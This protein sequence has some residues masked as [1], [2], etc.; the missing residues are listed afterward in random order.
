MNI[1]N[2]YKPF[3]SLTSLVTTVV[4]GSLITPPAEALILSGSAV[5]GGFN[6]QNPNAGVQNPLSTNVSILTKSDL[7]TLSNNQVG[8]GKIEG[9]DVFGLIEKQN[10]LLAD[11]L[12]VFGNYSFTDPNY[13][14]G[15]A[16]RNTLIK[17]MRVS[18]DLIWV[19]PVGEGFL[20]GNGQRYAWEG[21][22]QFKGRILGIL[23]RNISI[24]P[25]RSRTSQTNSIFGLDG[26]TYSIDQSLD[27]VFDVVTFED[28]KLDFKLTAGDGTDHFRVITVAEVP[29]PLTIL[30]SLVALCFGGIFKKHNQ[31]T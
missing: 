31:K 7:V 13:V 24:A 6:P 28:N 18:S 27:N 25:F 8:T 15:T 3:L 22:L 17:G 26:V 29:E 12:V 4:V 11:D 14:Q 21:T 16:I 1:A 30:G 20:G 5:I 2:I 9:T 10:V 19:D 23:P